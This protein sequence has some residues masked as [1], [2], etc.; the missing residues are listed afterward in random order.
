VRWLLEWMTLCSPRRSV[1][2][3]AGSAW[4]TAILWES[5]AIGR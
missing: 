2:H 1:Y 5:V 3:G 4:V